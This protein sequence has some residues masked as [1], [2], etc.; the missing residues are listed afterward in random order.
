MSGCVV[1]MNTPTLRGF[2]VGVFRVKNTSPPHFPT[3]QSRNQNVL[4]ENEEDE[5][6]EVEREG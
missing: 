2:N 6:G 4:S 3:R 5:R 1:K